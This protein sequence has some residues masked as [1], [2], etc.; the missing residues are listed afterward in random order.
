MPCPVKGEDEHGV[1]PKIL[2][3]VVTKRCLSPLKFTTQTELLKKL[4]FIE[5]VLGGLVKIPMG[6]G[7]AAGD[8]V[9]ERV[10]GRAVNSA[11]ESW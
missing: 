11:M 9:G 3:D 6:E 5:K 10:V 1:R 2:E 7:V 8:D 4:Y